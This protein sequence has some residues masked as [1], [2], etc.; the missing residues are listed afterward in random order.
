MNEIGFSVD[1]VQYNQQKS[2]Y[3]KYVVSMT[4]FMDASKYEGIISSSF[5]VRV[6]VCLSPVPGGHE[7]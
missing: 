5:P 7:T 6:A 1:F 3:P 4:P 2:N